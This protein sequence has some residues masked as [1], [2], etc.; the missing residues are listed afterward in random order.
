MPDSIDEHLNRMLREQT[1]GGEGVDSLA[2]FLLA[3]ITLMGTAECMRRL[4]RRLIA[5]AAGAAGGPKL[6]REDIEE[7]EAIRAE[8]GAL[9]SIFERILIHLRRETLND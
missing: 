9:P 7:L 2:H 6:L 8:L 3:S 5:R 4:Q 1:A